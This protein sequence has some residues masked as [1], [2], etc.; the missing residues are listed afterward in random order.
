MNKRHTLSDKRK[1]LAAR[2]LARKIGYLKT[3]DFPPNSFES[4]LSRVFNAHKIIRAKDE[5]FVIKQGVVEVWNAHQ[6]M[7]VIELEAGTIFGDMSLLGQSMFECQ[8]I[9]GSGGATLGVINPELITEWVNGDPLRI[10]GEIGPRLVLVEAEHYRTLFQTV[11]HRLAAFLL[12]LAGETSVIEGYTQDD[13]GEILGAY[14]ETITNT[15]RSMKSKGLIQTSRKR[16]TLVNKSGL[17]E[18]SR[19]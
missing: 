18:L 7:L 13:F 11:E 2:T 4:L 16:I 6:D 1:A 14:R 5:L 17:Q 12:E 19:L 8:A 15:L 3:Q 10:L 9:A